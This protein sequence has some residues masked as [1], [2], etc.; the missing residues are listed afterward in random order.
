MRVCVVDTPDG[1]DEIGIGSMSFDGGSLILFSDGERM[2]PV[3]AYGPY[4]W[5]RWRWKE[6]NSEV[7]AES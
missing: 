5:L 4:G 1:S 7:Q 6:A 3:T 2:N